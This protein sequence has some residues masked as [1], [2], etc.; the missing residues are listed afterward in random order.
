MARERPSLGAC[1]RSA[2]GVRFPARIGES[3]WL[4]VWQVLVVPM[5]IA[6][7]P[8]SSRDPVGT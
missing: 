2:S 7:I 3:W 8:L 1:R 4:A 6:D 5:R